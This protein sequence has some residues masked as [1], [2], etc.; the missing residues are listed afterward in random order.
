MKKITAL[1]VEGGRDKKVRL[2]LD[3]RRALTLEAE[4]ALKERLAVG[5]ELTEEEL[6]RLIAENQYQKCLSAAIHFL[7]YRP[8]S[9]SEV[10]DRLK[11]RG[12]VESDVDMV[13]A[14]L[15]E[16]GLIDDAAFAEFWRENREAF[17]PRSRGLT[18]LELRR[19]GVSPGIIRETVTEIDNAESA[20]RAAEAKARRIPLSDYKLFKNRLGGY[21]RRRGFNYEVINNTV[22]RFW[23]ELGGNTP[24]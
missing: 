23:R 18:A 20:Y 12:F 6:N 14:K 8:R 2:S 16:Q 17:S 24:E 9:E 11:R 19:K 3:G 1:Q 7:G 13:V 22:E 4:V 10:R 21:L 5:R 15:K